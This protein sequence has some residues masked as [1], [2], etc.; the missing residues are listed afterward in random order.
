MSE[1]RKKPGWMF[2]AIAAVLTVLV[3]VAAYAYMVEDVAV[4]WGKNSGVISQYYNPLTGLT[5][6]K[7]WEAVFRPIHWV[8]RRIRR[9]KWTPIQPD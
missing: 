5:G 8:D 7:V 9:E 3:Y 1:E 6:E 4:G 2:F